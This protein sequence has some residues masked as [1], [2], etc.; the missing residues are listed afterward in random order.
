[1]DVLS[2]FESFG[3]ALLVE[4]FWI[5]LEPCA[6]V[7]TAWMGV[8]QRRGSS[9][10][11]ASIR[12]NN[13]KLYLGTFDTAV[14]AARAFDD[15]AAFL[16]PYTTN[17]NFP[18]LLKAEKPQQ[19]NPKLIHQYKF[20]PGCPVETLVR[21]GTQKERWI[22]AE[23]TKVNPPDYTYDLLVLQPKRHGVNPNAVH[24]PEHYIRNKTY[25]ASEVVETR[26]R[27]AKKDE[28]CDTWIEAAVTNV[29]I[30]GSYDIEVTEPQKHQVNPLATHVPQDFLRPICEMS[31]EWFE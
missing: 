31:T 16:R 26:I 3:L 6:A 14:A 8:S 21:Y 15:K 28:P 13:R 29:H 30:D 24:V 10:F 12:H 22:D 17:V 19:L 18:E 11:I 5:E 27:Y 20:R 2:K 25:K 7:H 4:R 9:G 23:I 1:M